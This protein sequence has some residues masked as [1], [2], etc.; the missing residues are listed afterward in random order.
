MGHYR[1]IRLIINLLNTTVTE[2]D[3]RTFV[4]GRRIVH[5]RCVFNKLWIFRIVN[6]PAANG[7]QLD[8]VLGPLYNLWSH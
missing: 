8:Y 2:L 1:S 7:L 3:I 5:L 6:I 4:V